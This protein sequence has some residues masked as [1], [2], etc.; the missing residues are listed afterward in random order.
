V[1]YSI[2]LSKYIA[3]IKYS[4][5]SLS[6]IKHTE[7]L[8]PGDYT[9]THSVNSFNKNLILGAKYFLNFFR[10]RQLF[11]DISFT[12]SKIIYTRSQGCVSYIAYIQKDTNLCAVFLSTGKI[13][14]LQ[15]N[16]MATAGRVSGK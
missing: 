12:T 15:K 6:F 5:G 13:I 16:S 3:I 10:P 1:F 14:F 8:L 11:S 4:K 2:S 9:Y 7:G